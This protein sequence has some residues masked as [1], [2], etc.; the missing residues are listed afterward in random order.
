MKKTG[1]VLA[2]LSLIALISAGCGDFFKT[3]CRV[4]CETL[5]EECDLDASDD[6]V[7]DCTEDCLDDGENQDSVTICVTEA[8]SCNEVIACG[9]E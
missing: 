4:A 8:T 1:Y 7:D 3:N 6:E 5:N 9:F 2:L